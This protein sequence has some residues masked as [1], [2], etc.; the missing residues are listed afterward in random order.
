LAKSDPWSKFQRIPPQPRSSGL[1]RNEEFLNRQDAKT[2]S[3]PSL[4]NGK[5]CFR[6]T[7]KNFRDTHPQFPWRTWR[8]WRFKFLLPIHLGFQ[9]RF[10][11][12]AWRAWRFNFFPVT[13]EAG[14]ALKTRLP[15]PNR[16]TSAP[17]NR[18]SEGI[19]LN[20]HKNVTKRHFAICSIT[21]ISTGSLVAEERC[22]P[23][24][25][26]IIPKNNPSRVR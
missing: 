1:I 24:C 20:C 18:G 10:T 16:S 2:P 4:S 6:C 17:C 13:Q 21:T 23:V 3:S 15:K 5:S 22:H 26:G 14:G 19:F 11:Y 8:T 25:N 9:K 7:V 12:L